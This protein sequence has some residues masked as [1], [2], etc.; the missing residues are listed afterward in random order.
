MHVFLN[1]KNI[2]LF[3]YIMAVLSSQ[4]LPASTK[5]TTMEHLKFPKLFPQDD[6]SLLTQK[7]DTARN[8]N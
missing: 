2:D 3:S 1:L 4:N 5:Y 6:S 7:K 8:Y